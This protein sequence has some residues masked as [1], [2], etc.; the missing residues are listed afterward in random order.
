MSLALKKI[1]DFFRDFT[2]I[3]IENYNEWQN[4]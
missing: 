2:M 4:R 3:C 1:I